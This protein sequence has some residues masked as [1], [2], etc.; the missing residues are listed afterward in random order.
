VPITIITP[1]AGAFLSAGQFVQ[2]QSDF[3][4]PLLLPA[5]LE[6]TLS[7]DIEGAQKIG[8]VEIGVTTTSGLEQLMSR[9]PSEWT[10]GFYTAA[11]GET[12][13]LIMQLVEEQTGDQVDEGHP[14]FI[15]APGSSDALLLPQFMGSGSSGFTSTDRATLQATHDWSVPAS[16]IDQLTLTEISPGETSL[17]VQA[18]LTTWSYGV[19]I[20]LTQVPPTAVFNTPDDGYCVKT[21]AVMR[22]FRG[23]D[24][25]LRVPIHRTS[26]II[27]FDGNGVI[28]RIFT[29]EVDMWAPGLTIEV[30]FGPSTAGHVYLLKL[31]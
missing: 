26:Q 21:L 20:R 11:A 16:F 29:A 15:W 8:S 10:A 28:L 19:L 27:P 3:I 2:W 7:R 23:T 30:D 25:L 18:P 5:H 12:V 4:G 31:P 9:Q 13:Y 17:P 22:L 1:P 24:L 6:M 14:S